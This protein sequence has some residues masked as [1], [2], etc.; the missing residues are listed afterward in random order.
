M[1][2]KKKSND[3][4]DN[5][6]DYKVHIT[7]D[8][9]KFKIL[10]GN[11]EVGRIG[12]IKKHLKKYGYLYM[13]ILV[14]EFYEVIEGQHRLE[15][16]RELDI[17]IHYVVQKGL[18]KE[19]CIALN[20]GRRNWGA[21]DFIHSQAIDNENFSYFEIL[22]KKHPWCKPNMIL[23]S[24]TTSKFGGHYVDLV[25]NG[26]LK[27]SESDFRKADKVLT[28]LGGFNED[29]KMN[30][31]K[32][33][34]KDLI[35]QALIFAYKSQKVNNRLLTQ[36]VH[37]NCGLLRRYLAN[38]DDAIVA[39]E[40]VYNYKCRKENRIDLYSEFRNASRD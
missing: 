35:Y 5:V 1:E 19:H 14:N 21:R 9:G 24:Y 39:I 25:K 33:R 4:F 12:F 8:F 34:A 6:A 16:C 29:M 28:W 36:R 18:R 13:P 17:P 26:S 2:R 30:D 20:S 3:I 40:D 10:E 23:S 31:I 37:D 11:R 27:C 32:A 38:V 15:A 7:N 22:L